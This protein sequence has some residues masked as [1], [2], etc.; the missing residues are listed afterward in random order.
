MTIAAIAIATKM[1]VCKKKKKKLW[2][3]V[4]TRQKGK[5]G[6]KKKIWWWTAGFI[7]CRVEGW[8][9]PLKGPSSTRK[10]K[11]PHECC[12]FRIRFNRCVRIEFQRR[13][14]QF[15]LRLVCVLFKD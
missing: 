9:S 5:E 7:R 13:G 4:N 12:D 6:L 2:K 1:V 11:C 3:E 15:K 14:T 10:K 8:V